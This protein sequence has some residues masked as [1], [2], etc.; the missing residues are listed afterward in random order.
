MAQA[1]GSATGLAGTPVRERLMAVATRLLAENGFEGTS[2][3]QIVEAAGVTR[4]HGWSS[5]LHMLPDR[6]QAQ[7]RAERRRYHERFRAL[8]QE[9][10]ADGAFRA[11]VPAG[12]AVQ[13][14]LGAIHQLGSWFH[15]DGPLTPRQVGEYFADLLIEGLR[16]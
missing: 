11:E 12:I 10:M 7:V 1:R 8:V 5:S 3:Q 4:W 14:F 13:Y 2:V 15:P 6:Q 9:G 16:G